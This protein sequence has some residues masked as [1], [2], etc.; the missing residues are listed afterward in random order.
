M[1]TTIHFIGLI[2]VTFLSSTTTPTAPPPGAQLIMGRFPDNPGMPPHI[3]II[4]YPP[5]SRDAKSTWKE[6]SGT[7]TLPNGDV[8]NYVKVDA[9]NV[10]LT[11]PASAFDNKSLGPLPHLKCCCTEFA[12]GFSQDWG[13]PKAPPLNKMS[14]FFTFTIGTL[15]TYP[16][17]PDPDKGITT[18]LTLND[19]TM[20]PA[21]IT[22]T[23]TTTGK[24]TDTLII[25]PGTYIVV[26][27]EPKCVLEGKTCP[28]PMGPSDFLN[29]YKMAKDKNTCTATPSNPKTPSCAPGATCPTTKSAAPAAKHNYS[30]SIS[31]RLSMYYVNIDCS[32]SQWP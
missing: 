22:F 30:S 10:T 20:P 3:R 12:N 27:N 5:S 21:N 7:I 25:K 9:Q 13:S 18:I 1:T 2:V 17:P 31:A 26:A 11:G 28:P 32:N 14:A 24:P 15:T 16:D 19:S 29:Y 23:G 8:Y 6:E 4:A